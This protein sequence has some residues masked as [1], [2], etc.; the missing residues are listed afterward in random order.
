MTDLEREIK[1]LEDEVSS[2]CDQRDAI[3]E[4]ISAASKRRYELEKEVHL[5]T[6][7]ELKELRDGKG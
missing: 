5:A 4:K 3:Q 7:A 6:K 2:L 1:S